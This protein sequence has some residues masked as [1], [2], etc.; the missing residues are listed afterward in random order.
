MASTIV[1]IE[2]TKKKFGLERL[3][4]I[5]TITQTQEGSQNDYLVHSRQSRS[6]DPQTEKIGSV[7]S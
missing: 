4:R 6:P 3:P 2:K 1:R 7:I 5:S